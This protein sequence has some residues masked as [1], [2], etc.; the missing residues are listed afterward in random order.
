[1]FRKFLTLIAAL[2]LPFALFA[3]TDTVRLGYIVSGK[4]LDGMT[5]RPLESVHV[6]VP[7]RHYATVTNADGEFSIKSDQPIIEVVFSY[8]GYRTLRQRSGAKKMTVRLVPESISL[9]ESSIITG[10]PYEIVRTAV[11]LIPDN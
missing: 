7:E 11:N 6:S 4:V 9:D 8:V 10:D 1:M 5:G 2:V 3:Q